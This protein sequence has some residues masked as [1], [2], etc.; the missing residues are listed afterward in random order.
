M[1]PPFEMPGPADPT[2]VTGPLPDVEESRPET[3]DVP[4]IGTGEYHPRK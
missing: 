1:K 2:P 4:D 3:H